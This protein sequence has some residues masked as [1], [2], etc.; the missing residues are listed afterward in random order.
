MQF[1][2]SLIAIALCGATFA[3]AACGGSEA[4]P[5]AS[6]AAPT[7]SGASTESAAVSDVGAKLFAS[8][9][10][11]CHTLSAAGANGQVGPNLDALAPDQARVKQQVTNGGNGMPAFADVFSEAEIDAVAAYVAD[12]AGQ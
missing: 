1:P 6:T 10:A 8:N 2:K 4:Q 7:Q 12:S 9:C 11:Q 3:L 5:S